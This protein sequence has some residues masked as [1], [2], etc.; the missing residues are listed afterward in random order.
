M[1]EAN[2]TQDRVNQTNFSFQDKQNPMTTRHFFQRFPSDKQT[3]V[4]NPNNIPDLNLGLSLGGIYSSTPTTREKPLIR[5][6]SSISGGV[7]LEKNPSGWFENPLPK[8]FLSLARS[9]SLPAEVE[10]SKRVVDAK[11]LRTMKRVEAK[12]R[13][14]EK[15]IMYGWKAGDNENLVMEG[16]PSSP[17]KIPAWAAAS[18]AKSPALNR[19]ID[20][21]KEGFRQMEG[22]ISF[23]SSLFLCFICV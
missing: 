15:Q 20:K 4:S 8:S 22:M 19:A 3:Q 17:S 6:F 7:T 13:A 14:A 11:E 1:A 21:I 5:S 12:N 16:P 10:S 9:S 2:R 18:A 23:F